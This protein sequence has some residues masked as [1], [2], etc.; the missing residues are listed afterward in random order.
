MTPAENKELVKR[1]YDLV[2]VQQDVKTAE[3]II[4]PDCVRHD[5]SGPVPTGPAGFAAMAQKWRAAFSDFTLTV[6]VALA[7]NDLVAARWTIVAKHTGP[8]AAR[9]GS[10]N[11]VRFSGVNIFRLE[12]GRI[13]EIWNHRD[14]LS[15]YQQIGAMPPLPT[16]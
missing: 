5:P 4:A 10:G 13:A 9:P 11:P 6:D 8:F 15:L 12:G 16:Q 1:F 3:S 2:W 14:D 7:E